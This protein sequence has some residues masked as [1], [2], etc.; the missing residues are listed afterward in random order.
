MKKS[1]KKHTELARVTPKDLGEQFERVQKHPIGGLLLDDLAATSQF[2]SKTARVGIAADGNP[3]VVGHNKAAVMALATS[4]QNHTAVHTAVVPPL[5]ELD[6][7]VMLRGAA[8][9][10]SNELPPGVLVE[11]RPAL[12]TAEDEDEEE[13]EDET[14]H[15]PSCED[16]PRH[17]ARRQ[18]ASMRKSP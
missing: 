18:P 8:K 7:K 17:Q 6:F 15:R 9:A 2:G 3:C 5:N 10:M 14:G 4:I 12:P 1:R 11:E 13:V 16:H